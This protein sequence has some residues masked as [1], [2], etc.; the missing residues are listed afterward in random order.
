[1][2]IFFG[3]EARANQQTFPEPPVPAYLG[4]PTLSASATIAQSVDGALV[5]PTVWA[6][7]GL[8]ANTV[9]MLPLETY[10]RASRGVPRR[11]TDPPLVTMPSG[12][13]TQSE[14]LHMLMVSLLLR[15]NAFGLLT[16]DQ[17]Q[18][19]TGVTLLDPDKVRVSVEDG[20]AVYRI[21]SSNTDRSDDMWHVRGLTVPGAVTGLS[22]I[23]YAAATLGVDVHSRRFAGDFFR[24]GAHPSAILST[25]APVNSDQARTV[26]DRFVAAVRGREPAVLGAGLEYKQIQVSPDESQFLQTQKANVAQ[27]A[28]YFWI[29]PEMVGGES[30]GSLTYA[31]VEQRSLDF[32]TYAVSFWLKRIEDV[33]SQLL[34]TTQYVRFDTSALLR[35]DAETAAKV[36]AI[37]IA[38]KVVVPSEVRPS[39]DLPP[40]TDAQKEEAQMV[41]LTVTPLG[42]PR[43]VLKAGALPPDSTDAADQSAPAA[44]ARSAT[45]GGANG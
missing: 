14:W 42:A 28:R 13:L 19:A 39:L 26:K 2:G 3:R 11:V 27:I 8:L 9:S 40:M 24:D 20:R 7:V 30:G 17:D 34:P 6:C 31:N 43:A 4:A 5:V 21:G 38:S 16:R 1:M 23:G 41:P 45:E 15:G 18:Y 22:P 35:T 10:N 36:D 32:L 37:R 44:A 12:S 29:P 33:V 25:T